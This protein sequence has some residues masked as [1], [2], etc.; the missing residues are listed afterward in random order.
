MGFD[1]LMASVKFIDEAEPGLFRLEG[2]S[3]G[4]VRIA[5]L[6][7]RPLHPRR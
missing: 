3:G 4:A 7:P 1:F 2:E 5:T 6:R